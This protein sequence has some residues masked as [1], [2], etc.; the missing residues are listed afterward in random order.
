MKIRL[1]TIALAFFAMTA[2]N[3]CTN[4]SNTADS[5]LENIYNRKSVRQFT[6]E[7]VSEEHIQTMLKAAMAAGLFCSHT[8]PSPCSRS[9]RTRCCMDRS[10]S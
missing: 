10:I 3:S 1:L 5:A 6:S 4:T 2:M 9:S 8:E 7:P